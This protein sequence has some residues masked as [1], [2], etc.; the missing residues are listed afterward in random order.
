MMAAFAEPKHKAVVVG[1]RAV[2][3][4]LR[5]AVPAKASSNSEYLIIYYDPLLHFAI[6]HHPNHTNELPHIVY[7]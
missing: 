2:P 7:R 3:C 1:W 6:H 4:C 5:L